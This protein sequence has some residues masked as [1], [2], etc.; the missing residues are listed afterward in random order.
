MRQIERIDRDF[1]KKEKARK[2]GEKQEYMQHIEAL[3]QDDQAAMSAAKNEELL[4]DVSSPSPSAL[5]QRLKPTEQQLL[6][7]PPI[8]RQ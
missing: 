4:D 8:L 6:M 7:T 2:Q 5:M 3:K 1:S